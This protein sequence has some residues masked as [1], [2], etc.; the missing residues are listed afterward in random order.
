MFGL[1][2]K[3]R[4]PKF[5]LGP[6]VGSYEAKAFLAQRKIV[7]DWKHGPE[8]FAMFVPWLVD[9]QV[10][11]YAGLERQTHALIDGVSQYLDAPGPVWEITDDVKPENWLLIGGTW[12]DNGIGSTA[13]TIGG[14]AGPEADAARVEVL[15][16]LIGRSGP[17]PRVATAIRQQLAWHAELGLER[18]F[19]KQGGRMLQAWRLA[20][21]GTPR[22]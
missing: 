3:S 9:D 18:G 21:G 7:L 11:Y 4:F 14:P 20:T 15:K 19:A 10:H 1:F 5:K 8:A 12:H 17:D 22:E 13:G 2:G 6:V 16:A